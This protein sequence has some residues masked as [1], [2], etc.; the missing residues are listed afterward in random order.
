MAVRVTLVINVTLYRCICYGCIRHA[1][2]AASLKGGGAEILRP[3]RADGSS[4]FP[5]V[6]TPGFIPSPLRDGCQLQPA[7]SETGKRFRHWQ[8]AA[9]GTLWR[10]CRPDQAQLIR[11]S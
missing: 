5:G 8:Q 1:L 11:Q 7:A 2:P 3:F 9:S 4:P 10:V 6:E